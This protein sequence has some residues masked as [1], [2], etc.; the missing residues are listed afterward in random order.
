MSTLVFLPILIS[1]FGGALTLSFWRS[2]LWQKRITLV[3]ASIYLIFAILLQQQVMQDGYV[4]MQ[5]GNWPAPFGITLVADIL[6]ATMI[7]LTGIVG[8]ASALY[9]MASVPEQHIRFGYFP[10]LQ[11]LLAGVSGAFLT[12]DVF[13]LFVWFEVMLLASFGLLTLGGERAQ[14][15][16]AIKYVTINLLSSALFLSAIGLLYSSA[17]TLNIADLSIKLA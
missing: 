15:E 7:L 3:C 13:N 4:V 8:F 6:S 12:G 11:L 14:L 9:S 2:I 10:L 5:M 17:G 1:L 16:G